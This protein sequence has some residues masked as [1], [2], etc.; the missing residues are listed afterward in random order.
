LIWGPLICVQAT[1]AAGNVCRIWLRL[2][3]IYRPRAHIWLCDIPFITR[4]NV[5]CPFGLDSAAID[6]LPYF[7][8]L[9][10]TVASPMGSDYHILAY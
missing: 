3:A 5:Y 7:G 2:W 4:N 9:L 10:N 6:L 8:K 1:V